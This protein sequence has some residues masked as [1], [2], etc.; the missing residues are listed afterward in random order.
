M[1]AAPPL[2]PDGNPP[3]LPTDK[4][5][6][7]P[8]A[9]A[10]T[11]P[12]PLA[13][14]VKDSRPAPATASA[15]GL[16]AIGEP[17]PLAK[18]DK[19]PAKASSSNDSLPGLP[20]APVTGSKTAKGDDLPP[21][22]PTEDVAPTPRAAAS[23]GTAATTEQLRPI[24][25]APPPVSPTIPAVVA[26]NSPPPPITTSVGDRKSPLP[27]PATEATA[28]G[29]TGAADKTRVVNPTI[30]AVAPEASTAGV[31]AISV[32]GAPTTSAPPLS[33]PA[34]AAP[35]RPTQ[36]EVISYVEETHVAAAGDTFESIS[37]AKYETDKYARALY[38]FNRSH[39]LAG[40]ELLQ[41]DRLKPQQRVYIPPAEILE[42]RYAAAIK[43]AA[44]RPAV[45]VGSGAQH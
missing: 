25:V 26:G 29:T 23:G 17:P 14:P 6:A 21:P 20:P 38:L 36:P 19:G 3:P 13:P 15:P 44:A 27:A 37:R 22:L 31:K 24:P 34:T 5:A 35:A 2:P 8:A 30:E 32:G 4:P 28:K 41:D 45:S 1:T 40:D 11:M 16:P 9:V 18:N 43:D 42:S 33:V 12:P 39:P 10:D 7:A